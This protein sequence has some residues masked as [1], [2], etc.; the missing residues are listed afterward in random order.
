M[1][2]FADP[3]S[4]AAFSYRDD[5]DIPAFDDAFWHVVMDD[6]CGLCART[7]RRIA[8]LDRLDRVRIVPLR[9]ALGTGL[10]RHYGLDP[11]NPQSWLLIRHGTARAGFDAA[12]HLFPD[13]SDIYTPLLMLKIL[14]STWREALYAWIARHRYAWFGRTDLC[15]LPDP[16]VQAR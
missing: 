9:S 11:S 13:L 4:R 2:K 12:M 10:M 16:Q 1:K 15:A 6:R 14:P 8:H 5:P 3:A 7:A